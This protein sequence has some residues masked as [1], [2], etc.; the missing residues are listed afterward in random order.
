MTS[1]MNMNKLKKKRGY[2]RGSTTKV[3]NEIMDENLTR[4]ALKDKKE[5]LIKLESDLLGLDEKIFDL[6]IDTNDDD[7]CQQE[8][9]NN[10][11]IQESIKATLRAINDRLRVESTAKPHGKKGQDMKLP[12]LTLEKFDLSPHCWLNFWTQFQRI[13]SQDIPNEDKFSYL[14][15]CL[16]GASKKIIEGYPNT[17]DNYVKALAHLKQR[18]GRE[19]LII[20]CLYRDLLTYVKSDLSVIDLYDNLATKLRALET[21]GLSKERAE[22]LV[23]LIEETMPSDLRKIWE[24]RRCDESDNTSEEEEEAGSVNTANRIGKVQ[25]ILS[26]LC[27]E[28]ESEERLK[29]MAQISNVSEYQP[30]AAALVSSQPVDKKQHYDKKSHTVTKTYPNKKPHCVF[31]RSEDHASFKC[32][33]V[34]TMDEKFKH[35][36]NAR[37]CFKCLRENHSRKNCRSFVKC[38]I[39]G[40]GHY[41]IICNS[42]STESTSASMFAG[43]TGKITLKTFMCR[44]EDLPVRVLLDTASHRSY[45]SKMLVQK[46]KMSSLKEE[47]MRHMLF[48][49]SISSD[50]THKLYDVCLKSM[51][52]KKMIRVQ[53]LDQEVICGDIPS[54]DN[55]LTKKLLEQGIVLCDEERPIEIL[56]GAD[57]IGEL[58]IGMKSIEKGLIAFETVLGWCLLGISKENAAVCMS[59]I[60]M[61]LANQTT[62][63][64]DLE[65][66]GI[67]KPTDNNGNCDEKVMQS[68]QDNVQ[69]KDDRYHVLLPW[70]EG[71]PPI[72]TN[73]TIAEN[74]L[75]STLRRLGP[76]YADYD[77]VFKQWEEENIIEK[78]DNEDT[79]H[80]MPHRPVIKEGKTTKVRPVF[81]ASAKSYGNPSLNECLETGPNMIAEL[82]PLLIRFRHDMVGVISDIKQAFLM[83]GLKSE[84]DQEMLKF[85]W[86]RDGQTVTFRHKRVVFGVASSPF[87][88]NATIQHHLANLSGPEDTI[89]QEILDKL[90]RS[91]YMDDCITSLATRPEAQRFATD[92]TQI[93]KK[94]SFDLRGWV[95]S[96]D[97]VKEQG[98]LGVLWDAVND[99][100]GCPKNFY[101]KDGEALSKRELLSIVSKIFDPLGML[102]APVLYLKLALQEVFKL[103]LDWDIPI[104]Q[105]IQIK[106][107][108][109]LNE[110][111]LMNRIRVPR[112][113]NG[114][115]CTLHVFSDASLVGMGTCI[116]ARAEK[117][118]GVEVIF[119]AAKA[120]VTPMESLTIPRKELV[121]A[122]MASRL[123]SSIM[124]ASNVTDIT[125]WTDST[126]VLYWIKRGEW[127][128]FVG[129]RVKE[130]RQLT[131][132][133]QWRYVPGEMNPADVVS[134]G[135]LLSTYLKLA[136]W[137]GPH[138][139][140]DS[141]DTWPATE[142]VSTNM[143]AKDTTT[144]LVST[145]ACEKDE[146]LFVRIGK[147]SKAV[148]VIAW[149][150]RFRR[151][152][153]MDKSRN[154]SESYLS[155]E[156]ITEAERVMLKYIQKS[157]QIDVKDMELKM[158]S[159]GLLHVKTKILSEE[160][161]CNFREPIVLPPCTLVESMVVEQHEKMHHAGVTTVL[162][163]MREKFWII[164]GRRLVKKIVRN[165]VKCRRI[166]AKPVQT[167]A[168]GL[169]NNRVNM[170]K[171]FQVTGVDL[172]GPLFTKDGKKVWICLFTCAVYRAVHLELVDNLSTLCFE[173]AL[174][175]FIARRGRVTT[176]Y[177]DNGTNFRGLYNEMQKSKVENDFSIK[178]YFNVP[179]GSWWGGF[180]ERLIGLMKNLL[181]C[182]LGR[183]L[184]TNTELTT[185]LTEIEAVMNAR[186]ITHSS[187]DPNELRPITPSVFLQEET[188]ISV[189]DLDEINISSLN[190][191]VRYVHRVREGLRER[192]RKE[193]LG[194]LCLHSAKVSAP[195]E[196]GDIVWVASDLQKRVDWELGL[197][198]KVFPGKDNVV[199]VAL[200]K[201]ANS[202]FLRPVQKLCRMEVGSNLEKGNLVIPK[203]SE[204]VSESVTEE[205]PVVEPNV[206]EIVTLD[207]VSVSR[208]G[209]V[210]KKRELLDL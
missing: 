200:V 79:G 145:V 43:P 37:A 50:I 192:F 88:L 27:K 175:R 143:E 11:E 209:R 84:D 85:L 125:F 124:K 59:N 159:D 163:E 48:G 91:F 199:R 67:E 8:T 87:L 134:R 203:E 103:K 54:L 45:I 136:W 7:A 186:P 19:D 129:N 177:S 51:D 155:G 92:A 153:K 36:S 140:K 182:S 115:I 168:I 76:L 69:F 164:R 147:Y 61:N 58:V 112:Y 86:Q 64:W 31:C 152:V 33:K 80:F 205:F 29:A 189:P 1:K 108:Q 35:L 123:G 149:I 62:S 52:G 141:S 166:K 139:L 207:P 179:T 187:E 40:R 119:V 22:I 20:N 171:A 25:Q 110:V 144:S 6:M 122:L 77:N 70:K 90:K 17:G 184:L 28:A 104:P 137:E 180:F 46:L 181:K 148:R 195:I 201:T 60:V 194:S 167:P 156:E 114:N 68:F 101:V 44:I 128:T 30:T 49:G 151:N 18:F 100:M 127:K 120:R 9:D 146:N 190:N 98:V 53:C 107:D 81:D 183:A 34:M 106:C 72:P 133:E 10:L 210:V 113:M 176:M 3:I 121:G 162:S 93:M 204:I 16:E 202:E 131:S 89:E 74:R 174:R 196:V 26:F 24:R 94:A 41:D 102:A 116:F 126:I 197:V 142:L 65:T 99:V 158:Q 56:L 132:P 198:V 138:W 82:L 12:K 96:G 57:I 193:Y 47:S 185:M 165:C 135:C 73:Y 178:W 208:S 39:C 66:L 55:N 78:I 157:H 117:D 5:L 150:L 154:I 118:T 4:D 188:N 15:M 206:S 170:G 21:L 172:A 38:R 97:Q 169:P 42:T 95:M 109:W 63:L 71:H 111:D 13:D 160:F 191:R 32:S 173:Q 130:I 105:E 83:V 2:I 23:P 14:R 161:E 75:Q